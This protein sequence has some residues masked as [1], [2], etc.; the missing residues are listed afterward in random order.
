MKIPPGTS[1]TDMT[2]HYP[3]P[4]TGKDAATPT[5]P[6]DLKP[7][8]EAIQKVKEVPLTK[9]ELTEAAQNAP[10]PDSDSD[11][12]NANDDTNNIVVPNNN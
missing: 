3:I 2:N 5:K 1:S 9:T 7:P 8:V 11:S 12:S 10:K 4:E 6:V